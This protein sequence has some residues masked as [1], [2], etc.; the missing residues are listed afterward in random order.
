MSTD[1]S[2]RDV[3]AFRWHAQGLDN[4][5][6]S[7][8][9]LDVPILDYGVQDTGPDGAGW[10]LVTRGARLSDVHNSD[11]LAIAWTIRG[12]PHMYRRA[13][14]VELAVAMRPMSEADASKRIFNASKPL[15]AAGITS[16]EAL[17]NVA[18][19]LRKIVE[20]PTVKGDASGRLAK[21]MTEPYLRF[22]RPCNAT[23]LYEMPFRLAALQA[24][25][26]LQVGTS[27]PV[28]QRIPNWRRSTADPQQRI[29]LI[30]NYL[31]FFGPATH[32][33]VAAF[34][35]AP[36][37]DVAAHWPK[38]AAGV[39]VDGEK[40]SMLAS[41]AGEISD[42]AAPY[43]CRLLGPYD[44]YMQ[45]RDRDLLVADDARRK[46][47]WPALG[48]PGIILHDGEIVGE[49]R[50]KTTGKK[51][52]LRVDPWEPLTKTARAAIDVQGELLAEYRGAA[53]AGILAM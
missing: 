45:C 50:P 27:P 48:R 31:R 36:V 15:E 53:Y 11:S 14:L 1:L 39:T 51:F 3:L 21:V 22:C 18:T 9:A 23:H 26:E 13:D 20:K 7:V 38:D 41:Q 5:P 10:A 46:S 4:E 28:L 49:W 40:R 34:I 37:K 17:L 12:A 44:L 25:L 43:G 24:G 32:K 35:D 29:D 52:S 2:R 30:R 19:E 8:A 6:Q 16:T 42:T 47:L 33:Q